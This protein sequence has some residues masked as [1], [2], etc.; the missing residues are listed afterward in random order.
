LTHRYIFKMKVETIINEKDNKPYITKDGIEL[1]KFILEVGDVILPQMERPK[2]L[3][4]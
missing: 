2:F 4:D 1:Q 3:K